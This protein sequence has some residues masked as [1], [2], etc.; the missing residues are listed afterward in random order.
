ML[1]TARNF[2]LLGGLATFVIWLIAQISWYQALIDGSLRVNR[3][4]KKSNP[5]YPADQLTNIF[6]FIQVGMFAI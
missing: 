4:V 6:W 3:P 5:P 1:I 2:I